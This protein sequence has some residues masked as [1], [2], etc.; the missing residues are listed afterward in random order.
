MTK[1]SDEF[2]D[3]LRAL[4]AERLRPVPPPPGVDDERP[5]KPR[6][7]AQAINRLSPK[8]PTSD[9]QA[10]EVTLDA[11]EAVSGTSDEPAEARRRRRALA[12]PLGRRRSQDDDEEV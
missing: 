10:S 2:S 1:R 5:Q 7:R 11:S 4:E 8:R 6:S 12:G 3:R 9:S